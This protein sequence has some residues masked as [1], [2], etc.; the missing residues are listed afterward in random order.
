MARG[1]ITLAKPALG[2]SHTNSGLRC[3]STGTP[4][5]KEIDMPPV[6]LLMRFWPLVLVLLVTPALAKPLPAE[7]QKMEKA[8][9]GKVIRSF[10][11]PEGLTGW[12]VKVKHHDIILYSLPSGNYVLSGAL[13]GPDGK[14][15]TRKYMAE[16]IPKPDV[17]K[18]VSVLR[19]DPN[20]VTEG[21]PQALQIYVYADPNCIY[22]NLFWTD[23]R[24]YVNSGEVGVHWVMVG[25]L[26]ASS[27]GRAA[28]IL[29]ARNR[30]A[31]LALDETKFDK[32]REEG[33]I[34]P[35]LP[36]P[37]GV[38][39]VLKAHYGQMEDAGG[40]GTPT[41]IVRE[42][43]KWTGYYGAPRNIKA[44]MKIVSAK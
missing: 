26:K 23:L 11:G 3:A 41:I 16:Y 29:N 31:A 10:P 44:F 33:G 6:P 30:A 42:H 14:N 38:Q 1:T 5:A 24:P 37:K 15:L 40:R 39:A 19:H 36:V 27:A 28:A 43:G 18:I 2:G 17:A 4:F 9:Y 13:V 25:F 20:L 22:C 7:L 32:Q 12:V 34:P 35:L 8:G 21:N